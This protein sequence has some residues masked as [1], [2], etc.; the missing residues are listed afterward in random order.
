MINIFDSSTYYE[1]GIGTIPDYP[2][3]LEYFGKAASKRHA[4]AA[5]KLNLPV[6]PRR[7]DKE[8]NASDDSK[9]GNMCIV[10]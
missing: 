3:A 1:D 5:A 10:I 9:Q 2:R 7:E 8:D 4:F 6:K